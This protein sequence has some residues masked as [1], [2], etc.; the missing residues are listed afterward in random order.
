MSLSDEGH[1]SLWP[2]QSH[3]FEEYRTPP[4]SKDEAPS[5]AS[6]KPSLFICPRTAA[7]GTRSPDFQKGWRKGGTIL[8]LPGA[9][10]SNLACFRKLGVIYT[11]RPCLLSKVRLLP[12]ILSLAE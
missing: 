6:K 2:V 7:V 8:Y 12:Y 4:V 9:A 10:H 11:W 5:K 3:R 1:L